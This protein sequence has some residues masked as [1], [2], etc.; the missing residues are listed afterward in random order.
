MKK[1]SPE[2]IMAWLLSSPS[3]SDLDA[4]FPELFENVRCEITTIISAGTASELPAYLK[5]LSLTERQLEK[6]CASRRGDEHSASALVQ[7]AL[8]SRMAHLVIKQHLISEAT[9]IEKGKVR[10]NLFNGYLARSCYLQAVLSENL[11]QW[12]CF[13]C[14]GR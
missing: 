7:Q 4:Q 6:K 3:L 5:R 9:G 1:E 10:F 11:F 13:A 8:H 2:K 12:R 14:S